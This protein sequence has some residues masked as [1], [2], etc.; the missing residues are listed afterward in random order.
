MSEMI[1][2]KDIKERLAHCQEDPIHGVQHEIIWVLKALTDYLIAQ[3]G[4]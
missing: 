1:E 4:E 3:E 2:L